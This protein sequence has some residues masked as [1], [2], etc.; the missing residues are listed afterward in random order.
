MDE[1]LCVGVQLS[2]TDTELEVRV[3]DESNGPKAQHP[4]LPDVDKETLGEEGP[5]GIGMFL[6]Q[7]L[8]D[9]AEWHESPPGKCLECAQNH[10]N[11]FGSN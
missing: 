5:R 7:A 3:S 6:I 1:N 2:V 10:G 11:T 8:V 4:H 9:E